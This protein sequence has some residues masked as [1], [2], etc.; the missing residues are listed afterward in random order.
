MYC[1]GTG[2]VK[3]R[4]LATLHAKRS[5]LSGD[6]RETAFMAVMKGGLVNPYLS[7]SNSGCGLDRLL[8]LAQI[9]QNEVQSLFS[10]FCSKHISFEKFIFQA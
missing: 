7:G 1:Q 2:K 5:G 8:D 3:G 6:H 9:L 4:S 10:H